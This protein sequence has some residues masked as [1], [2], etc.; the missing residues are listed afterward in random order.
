MH[1]YIYVYLV[2]G[3]SADAYGTD[4]GNRVYFTS[5]YYETE[6]IVLTYYLS[7][8]EIVCITRYANMAYTIIMHIQYVAIN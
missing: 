2:L 3:F 1:V 4:R 7:T 8:T 5:D 6:C